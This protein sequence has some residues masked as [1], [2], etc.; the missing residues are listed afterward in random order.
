MTEGFI[1][2]GLADSL[3]EKN[4]VALTPLGRI[5]RP[6]DIGPPVVFLASEEARWITGETMI[7][8]GGE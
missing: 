6:D 5:G 7:V 8:S 2:A 4:N 3:M 1:S